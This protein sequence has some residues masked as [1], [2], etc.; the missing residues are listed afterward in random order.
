VNQ[1]FHGVRAAVGRDCPEQHGEAKKGEQRRSVLS[2]EHI[3]Q[4]FGWTPGVTLEE[5]LRTT[6]DYFRKNQ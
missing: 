6:V 3:R 4:A 5:G 2:H 1:I